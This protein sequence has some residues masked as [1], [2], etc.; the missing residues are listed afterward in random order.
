MWH[1][2]WYLRIILMFLI[3]LFFSPWT[4]YEKDP[5]SLSSVYCRRCSFTW[6]HT[7]HHLFL[8]HWPVLLL[9]A[10]SW[11]FLWWYIILHPRWKLMGLYNTYLWCKPCWLHYT[12][13]LHSNTAGDTRN[14]T[15]KIPENMIICHFVVNLIICLTQ[16][17]F[18]FF[19]S[20]V[21]HCNIML[22]LM[23]DSLHVARHV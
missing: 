13:T 23:K 22:M 6:D 2:F 1:I 4:S 19:K 3:K 18:L 11:C 9:L 7:T 16:V 12:V 8:G 21:I 15:Q 5:S 10:L 17:A 20:Y 14:P